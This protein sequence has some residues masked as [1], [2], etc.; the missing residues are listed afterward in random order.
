MGIDRRSFLG[1]GVF[2]AGI[3]AVAISR[4][5]APA[6]AS[7]PSIPPLPTS[8][9]YVLSDINGTLEWVS[10]ATPPPPPTAPAGVS[11]PLLWDEVFSSPSVNPRLWVAGQTSGSAQGG[12]WET[13]GLPA[14]CSATSAEGGNMGA[15][16]DPA[17]IQFVPG[18]GVNLNLAASKVS[19]WQYSAACLTSWPAPPANVFSVWAQMPSVLNGQWPAIWAMPSANTSVGEI[20]L[21][22]GGLLWVPGVGNSQPSNSILCATLH[23]P[24]LPGGQSQSGVAL[25]V[26]LSAAVHRFDLIVVPGVSV[27][28][29]LDGTRTGYWTTSPP[30]GPYNIIISNPVASAEA[31]SYHETGTPTLPSSLFIERVA[32]W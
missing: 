1:A 12:L 5:A 4:G 28:T 25:G 24:S 8:G 27:E 13:A 20:D 17:N 11:A 3:G 22:E 18:G 16:Y 14:G 21:H 2:G 23:E 15:Y 6:A 9:T 26:D 30:Q 7:T 31:S 19:G 29:R 10:T 32:A